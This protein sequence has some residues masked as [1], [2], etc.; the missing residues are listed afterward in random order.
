MCR[1]WSV[2]AVEHQRNGK[3]NTKKA[4][5]KAAHNDCRE[6]GKIHTRHVQWGI[7]RE[8]EPKRIY[9]M[10]EKKNLMV[11]QRT[12]VTLRS[13]FAYRPSV[14]RYIQFSSKNPSRSEYVGSKEDAAGRKRRSG[15]YWQ[16]ALGCA[17]NIRDLYVSTWVRR[18]CPFLPVFDNCRAERPPNVLIPSRQ[19][20]ADANKYNGNVH[21]EA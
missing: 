3:T 15:N 4:L 7:K 5:Q 14:R 9:E 6:K 11:I 19:M 17:F 2:W 16:L 8:P 12:D 18:P 10:E 20:R 21:F 1:L 13:A